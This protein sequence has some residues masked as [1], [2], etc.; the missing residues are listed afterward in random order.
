MILTFPCSLINYLA[1]ISF[2][3]A[4]FSHNPT[5]ESKENEEDHW[6]NDFARLIG[7]LNPTSQ[8]ITSTLAL[9]SASV[10]NG[11]PLP[12]YLKVPDPYKLSARLEA[13]DKDI[14][15]IEHVL[16]PG[17][18]AFAVMQIASGLVRDDLDE[19]IEWVLPFELRWIY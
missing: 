7:G 19:L 12:P 13:L 15:S 3:S 4:T 16:E 11:T 8:E 10:A 17:Y 18:S 2:A 6:I 9:L 14:L 5:K 1:L